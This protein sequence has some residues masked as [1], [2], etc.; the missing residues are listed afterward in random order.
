MRHPRR[1]SPT[2]GNAH[3]AVPGIDIHPCWDQQLCN[4]HM[5]STGRLHQSCPPLQMDSMPGWSLECIQH[6]ILI[7][8]KLCYVCLIVVCVPDYVYIEI[9]LSS[10]LQDQNAGR[11]GSKHDAVVQG[12]CSLMFLFCVRLCTCQSKKF[13]LDASESPISHTTS[14]HC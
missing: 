2:S 6:T 10:V 13:Q 9:L 8:L 5:T 12:I 11:N 7:Y 1:D 3:R 4:I 14:R